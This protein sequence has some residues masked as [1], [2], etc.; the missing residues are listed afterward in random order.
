[1]THLLIVPNNHPRTFGYNPPSDEHSVLGIRS[2]HPLSERFCEGDSGGPAFATV[3]GHD[4]LVG[5]LALAYPTADDPISACF[6][7]GLLANLISY[8]RDRESPEVPGSCSSLENLVEIERR[9]ANVP[10]TSESSC[11][12]M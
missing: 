5:S 10:G 2:A 4:Y 6:Y 9:S 12:K 7:E 1:L 8:S 11:N 3:D